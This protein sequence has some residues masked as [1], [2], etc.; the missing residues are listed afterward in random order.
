[1]ALDKEFLDILA[2]PQCKG[3]LHT[4]PG[5]DGLIC[6]AC[7]LVYPVKDEIPI[8]LVQEAKPYQPPETPPVS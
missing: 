1:M 2:C 5:E 6:Q 8:L 7:K 3:D 4:T